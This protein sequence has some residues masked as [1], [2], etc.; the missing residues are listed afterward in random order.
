VVVSGSVE[1]LSSTTQT[2]MAR[3]VTLQEI[4]RAAGVS[5]ATVSRVAC[6]SATVSPGVQELVRKAAAQLGASL[7]RSSN[8]QT[9]T[10]L[11]SNRTR[12]HYFHSRVLVGAEAYLAEH[13]FTLQYAALSYSPTVAPEK[14]QA[15]RFFERRSR[16]SGFIVAGTSSGNLLELLAME[17]LP[18]SVIGNNVVGQWPQES[19]DSV[20]FDDIQGAYELTRFLQS[21]GHEDIWYVG[22]CRLPWYARCYEG[23]SR[24][25]SEAG[26][27]CRISE[28]NTDNERELGLLATK[29]ILSQ[30]DP[31]TA[32]FAGGDVVAQGVYQA[33]R[34]RGLRVSQDIG[35]AGF[36]DIE[37]ENLHPS[38]TTVRVFAEQVGRNLAELVLNRL[39]QPDQPPQRR[40]VPTQIIR[41]ESSEPIRRLQPS[42]ETK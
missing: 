30:G 40:I 16:S 41:R 22:N 6:K 17:K 34:D 38:L 39:D 26:L 10:F 19:C 2:L 28:F 14:I 5:P 15:S 23:Y 35:V 11:L 12:L 29:S 42:S 4:A 21:Q 33:L 7:E 1:N 8:K 9:I 13:D 25:M 36:N 37:A 32:I 3:K 24:A 31:V 20:W 18:F 27:R